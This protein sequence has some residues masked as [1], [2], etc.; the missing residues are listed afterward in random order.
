M[1]QFPRIL[2]IATEIKDILTELN[3]FRS[4]EICAASS[5]QHILTLSSKMT[6]APKAI[7][8]YTGAE[9][10]EA[11]IIR[12]A[13]INIVVFVS[14]GDDIMPLLQA[15]EDRLIPL[16]D[17]ND[18]PQYEVTASGTL[19]TLIRMEPISSDHKTLSYVINLKTMSTIQNVDNQTEG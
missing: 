4:V 12:T 15:I 16:N 1:I 13:E 17:E 3:I 18:E 14:F 8:V 10:D 6:G 2:V 5:Y 7:V 11:T 19:V 9:Y